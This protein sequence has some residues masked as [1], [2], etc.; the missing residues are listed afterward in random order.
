MTVSTVNPRVVGE[1][2]APVLDISHVNGK[3]GSFPKDDN[4]IHI[5]IDI[6]HLIW[7]FCQN[8]IGVT[9]NS[10]VHSMLRDYPWFHGT[11][12]R[13]DASSLVLQEHFIAGS[14]ANSNSSDH[15]Q[16]GKELV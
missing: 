7:I 16:S 1:L 5:K 11:L 6:K 2:G 12:S 10:E 4:D 15:N 3:Y 13:T 14:T 9:G 8:L